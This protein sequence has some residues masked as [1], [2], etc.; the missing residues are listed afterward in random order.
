MNFT[1]SDL[2]RAADALE[3]LQQRQNRITK[4]LARPGA[5]MGE[6]GQIESIVWS[7]APFPVET[8]HATPLGAIQRAQY[9]PLES[10][11]APFGGRESEREAG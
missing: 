5:I 2:R 6:D 1:V 3:A 10:L 11:A 7:V 9:N 4:L 8:E